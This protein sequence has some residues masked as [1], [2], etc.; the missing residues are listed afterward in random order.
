MRKI[1]EVG[2]MKV[3]LESNAATPYVIKRIFGFDIL[4]FLHDDTREQLE[5]VPEIEK[6]CYAMKLQAEMSTRDALN[7]TDDGFY[8]WL[9][10]F[11]FYDMVEILLPATVSLWMESG[12]AKS[13]PK[14]PEGP[15]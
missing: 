5:K 7:A 11:N 9:A 10:Q 1:I 6:M 14:N 4:T 13:E 2:D 8:D 12:K 15:Q 3:E